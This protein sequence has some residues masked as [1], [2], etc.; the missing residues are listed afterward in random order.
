MATV[1]FSLEAALELQTLRH[2][3]AICCPSFALLVRPRVL[4]GE[5]KYILYCKHERRGDQ[6]HESHK[7]RGEGSCMSASNDDDV[8]KVFP[9]QHVMHIISVPF[10][11]EMYPPVCKRSSC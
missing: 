5:E 4:L 1:C 8:G 9:L 7:R 6:A 10:N 3:L 2:L 11:F